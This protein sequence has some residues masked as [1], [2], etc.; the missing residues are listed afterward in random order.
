MTG[1]VV[2]CRVRGCRVVVRCP[3]GVVRATTPLKGG[4]P[5]SGG[6]ASGLETHV[7]CC[8]ASRSRVDVEGKRINL[9]CG[10]M[11]A[12]VADA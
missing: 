4:A 5:K 2:R 12:Y 10:D 11:R 8:V 7:A 3:R 9:W 6:G 1:S